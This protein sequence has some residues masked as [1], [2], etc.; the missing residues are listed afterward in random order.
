MQSEKMMILNML[1]EGKISADEA[2][3]LL[4]AASDGSSS[5]SYKPPS[6]SPRIVGHDPQRPHGHSPAPSPSPAAARSPHVPRANAPPVTESG[7]DAMGRKIS[8]FVKDATPKVKEFAGKVVE[9]TAGAADSISKSLAGG[10]KVEPSHYGS[11]PARPASVAAGV[12]ELLEIKV[13]HSNG[14]LNLQGLNGQVLVKGYNGDKISAKLYTVAK[15]AGAKANLATLG[16]K[17][18]LSYDENDFDRVC[19]DA[20]V[21]EALFQTIKAS[22]VNGDLSVST[23][24]A[25]YVFVENIGGNTEVVGVK[26]DNLHIESNNGTLTIKE[27]AAH[28]ATAEN[29][30]GPIAINKI[31]IGELKVNTFN[32]A[33]E[34]QIAD[35]AAYDNYRWNVETSNGKL[36][37]VLP[38]YATIGYHIKGHAALD[39]VKL[40]LVGMNYLRHDNSSL[41]AISVNYETCLKKVDMELATSNAPLVIN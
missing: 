16:N 32:G 8:E 20:F 5:A 1:N 18:Y 35:F 14:E 36:L 31:D 4:A 25:N 7:F 17:Y 2:S 26:S 34:M 15:R 22:T 19:I 38:S 13:E 10:G 12:E 33:I 29:F 24:S 30:N 3:R 6:P 41:E 27:T 9:K 28:K 37:V 40:G 11:A 39:T 21:P 23:V